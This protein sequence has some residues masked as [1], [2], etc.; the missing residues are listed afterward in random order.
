MSAPYRRLGRIMKVHGTKGEVSVAP[1]DDLSFLRATSDE[2]WIVPPPSTGAIPRRITE[3]RQGAK[4][5]LVR[6]DG[7]DTAAGAHELVGRWFISAGE[8]EAI[9]RAGEEF[10]G[11]EVFDSQ[12]GSLGTIT[13]IIITGA[14]DVLVVD[15][16]RFGQV[17]VPVIDQVILGVD[18]SSRTVD[19]ALLDG[20]IDGDR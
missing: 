6:I 12:R 13:D 15:G 5:V 14:N 8:E 16:G 9:V 19:V 4:G 18:D 10:L 3:T 11:Y 20:L 7:V 1:R 2:V 17:L